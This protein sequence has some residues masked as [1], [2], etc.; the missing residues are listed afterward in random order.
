[1]I[2]ALIAKLILI[3][4]LALAGIAVPLK[5]LPIER[6]PYADEMEEA[7]RIQQR[8]GELIKAEKLRRGIELAEEDVWE[9][10]I[11][12]PHFTAITTTSGGAAEKRTCQLPDFAALCVKYFHEAGLK[13]GDRVGANFS[14]SYPGLNLAAICAAEAMGLELVYSSSVGS[15]TYGANC[16]GYTFPEMLKTLYDAGLI[17]RMPGMITLGGGG[18]MGWNMAGYELEDDEWIAEI[19]DMKA[20]LLEEGLA[21]ETNIESYSQDIAIHEALYG[22]VKAFVNAGGNGLGLGH[23]DGVILEV[24]SGL[25]EPQAVEV[26][27]HSGFVERY[28]AKGIPVIHL[29]NVHALCE[30]GIPFDPVRPPEIGT[31]PVYYGGWR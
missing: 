13:P 8:A 17:S 23:N 21:Y 20:R 29:L 16:P 28:L 31:S 5:Q 4:T 1:M 12:G 14:G 9:I 30:E 22:D 6:L 3:L 7:A 18:D 19:E 24:G 2:G 27:E 11:M 26:N 10:G 25:L 15:S